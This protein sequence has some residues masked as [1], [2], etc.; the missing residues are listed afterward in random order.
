MHDR[1]FLGFDILLCSI[2]ISSHRGWTF[3]NSYAKLCVTNWIDVCEKLKL[4]KVSSE[5]E[6]KV[7]FISGIFRQIF[8]LLDLAKE[9]L[10]LKITIT[11][12]NGAAYLSINWQIIVKI[13]VLL[14]AFLWTAFSPNDRIFCIVCQYTKREEWSIFIKKWIAIVNNGTT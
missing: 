3:G 14:I 11:F 4:E 8:C 5:R 9:G 12:R 2:P 6:Q 1:L 7:G 13:K 10:E